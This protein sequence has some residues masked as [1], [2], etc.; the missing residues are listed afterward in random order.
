[1]KT[2]IET[3]T[4]TDH[5]LIINLVT[6]LAKTCSVFTVEGKVPSA[7]EGKCSRYT[8]VVSPFV[9]AWKDD[10]HKSVYAARTK[11]M[12]QGTT[13]SWRVVLHDGTPIAVTLVDKFNT[14]LDLMSG[15]R[16]L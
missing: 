8:T 4:T 13:P 7:D 1:M 9:P 15:A 14:H 10:L 2:N 12:K 3:K 16:S 6:R 5:D 11:A